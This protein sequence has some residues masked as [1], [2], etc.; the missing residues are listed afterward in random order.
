M[1][2]VCMY[3]CMYG[4][5]YV[6]LG[7]AVCAQRVAMHQRCTPCIPW[8]QQNSVTNEMLTYPGQKKTRVQRPMYHDDVFVHASPLVCAALG[9]S[10]G[11][12]R[13]G[14]GGQ[15][16]EDYHPDHMSTAVWSDSFDRRLRVSG[17]CVEG[18]TWCALVW[19]VDDNVVCSS[20]RAVGRD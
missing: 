2:G 18:L 7:T 13:V 6:C 15:R 16:G 9:V 20:A 11:G 14:R 1:T 17:A 4:C 10:Q 19:G 12:Q 8:L 5:I 3:V